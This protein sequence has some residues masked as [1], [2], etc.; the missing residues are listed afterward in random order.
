M[1]ELPDPVKDVVRTYEKD[2]PNLEMQLRYGETPVLPGISLKVE[3]TQEPPQVTLTRQGGGQ[4]D[5]AKYTLVMTDP[6]A[7]TPEDPNLREFL[8]WLV[9]DVPASLDGTQELAKVGKEV[10]PY[11]GPA[12]PAGT[13]RY[14]F[15]LFPQRGGVKAENLSRPRFSTQK[16]VE[17]H[18][19][20][21][22]V[23]TT[24]FYAAP[25]GPRV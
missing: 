16:F 22:A 1:A 6:D 15:L 20:A 10:M 11:M 5:D 4:S 12:P 23:A 8:H 7:P 14:I 24:Y 19:L 9:T 17:E 25:D 3:G 13:H 21:P 2:D 18:G